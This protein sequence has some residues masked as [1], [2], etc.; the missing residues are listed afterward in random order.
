MDYILKGKVI[1]G[2]I[3]TILKDIRESSNKKYFNKIK[4]SND[5]WILT[6]CPFHKDGQENHPSFGIFRNRDGDR[7]VGSY[8][9]F[10]CHVSGDL[11]HLVSYCLELDIEDATQ[12]L[13]DK[14]GNTFIEKPLNLPKIELD[15]NKEKT[16]I[17]YMDESVLNE[18][19]YLHPYMFKRKL[20]KEVISKYKIGYD[21]NTDSIT[22]PMWD[23]KNHLIAVNKRCVK[24]KKYDLQASRFKAVY[25]LN[26]ALA[27][28][29]THV[30]VCESQINALTLATYGL[31]AIALCG[32]GSSK[33]YEI[34]KNCGIKNFTLCFDGDDAGR[35]GTYKFIK[36]VCNDSYLVD[37]VD[38]PNGKDINDLTQYEFNNLDRLTKWEWYT[39]YKIKY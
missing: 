22:F 24:F 18:Y 6:Q 10:T 33:Q 7:T 8:H 23:E 9:C 27:E 4:I 2:D 21:K 20:T 26:F 14:Y 30:Y 13:L 31:T 1:D 25:L 12:W 34:L 37:I 11:V 3:E 17:D 19:N 36:N 15:N 28:K 5:D 35:I 16:S 39:K 32:T 29:V 38:V